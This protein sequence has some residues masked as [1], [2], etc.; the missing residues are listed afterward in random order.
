MNIN[1]PAGEYIITGYNPVTGEAHS[2]LIKVLARIV[3]NNDLVK[4]YLNGSQYVVRII[5]DDALPV[6]EG[7]SVEFNINGV[8]YTRYTNASGYAK[9]NINLPVGEYI[10]TAYHNGCTVSN[11]IIVLPND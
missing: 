6:G 8:F 1:L 3:E 10:I 11:T 2:N 9:L 4:R 7:V 5:G